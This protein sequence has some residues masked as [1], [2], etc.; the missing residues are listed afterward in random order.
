[1]AFEAIPPRFK[2]Y[3]NSFIQQKQKLM[4]KLKL[5]NLFPT[6]KETEEKATKNYA[7]H[8]GYCGDTTDL[9]TAFE[10]SVDWCKEYILKNLN[11]DNNDK[12][13]ICPNCGRKGCCIY[14]VTTKIEIPFKGSIC[15][16]LYNVCEKCYNS[17]KK[18]SERWQRLNEEQKDI[19]FDTTKA[20]DEDFLKLL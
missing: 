12:S 14:S 15:S 17:H 11:N 4:K 18:L 19:P 1:M 16:T 9:E 2:V 7:Y 5:E 20:I 3:E 6:E 10:S 8:Y 13:N